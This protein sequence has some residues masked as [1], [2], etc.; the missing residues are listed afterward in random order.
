MVQT[1]PV[2]T[3]LVQYIHDYLLTQ[4]K[5]VQMS[6]YMYFYLKQNA[7]AGVF[8]ELSYYC[9]STPMYQAFSDLV[10][11]EKYEPLTIEMIAAARK[12]LE[13]D[14]ALT[15]KQ[16]SYERRDIEEIDNLIIKGAPQLDDLM[17]RRHDYLQTIEELEDDK[18]ETEAALSDL[19]FLARI[20][21]CN[22]PAYTDSDER[23]TV[24]VAH[25]CDPNA[26]EDENITEN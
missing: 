22:D 24:F 9:R 13:N 25:E 23:G 7:Q 12:F 26:R 15:D 21:D 14:L 3:K 17:D 6:A 5:G 1:E 20:I 16:I 2:Q 8:I 19:D 11:W 4:T 10:G 18:K